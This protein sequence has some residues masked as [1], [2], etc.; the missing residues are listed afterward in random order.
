MEAIKNWSYKK[1]SKGIIWLSLNV[2]EKG[3]N[4]L[5]SS[6]L[7]ELDT[8]L[9]EIKEQAPIGL[10][11]ISGKPAG[12]IAGADIREFVG[13]N[14]IHEAESLIKRG[15]SVFNKLENLTFPTVAVING[16]CLG[17]GLELALAC[18]YRVALDEPK[19]KIGLPE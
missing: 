11:V 2:A 12:F 5:S 15:Q 1:D 16:V 7:N 9:D 8:L 3:M 17:G 13:I 6:V 19:T 10:A 4:V 14:N 18:D